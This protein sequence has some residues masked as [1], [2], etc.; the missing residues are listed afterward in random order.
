M[1]LPLGHRSLGWGLLLPC[2]LGRAGRGPLLRLHVFGPWPHGLGVYPDAVHDAHA[3]WRQLTAEAHALMWQDEHV[4]LAAVLSDEAKP[5]IAAMPRHF[6][7][8]Q[9]AG[10]RLSLRFRLRLRLRLR[11]RQRRGHDHLHRATLRHDLRFWQDFLRPEAASLW[12]DGHAIQ[13]ARTNW[14]Q[15]TAETHALKWQHEHVVLAAILPDEPKPA[16]A[17]MPRHLTGKRRAGLRLHLRWRLRLYCRHDHRHT[18][19]LRHDLRL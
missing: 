6:T 14:W 1:L 18:G 13:D 10:L 8:K 9:L 16:I 15:L 2:R 12:V 19:S 4:L 7:S 17:A 5:A 11:E 3:D